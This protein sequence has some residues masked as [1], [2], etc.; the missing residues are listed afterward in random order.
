M[1]LVISNP[2]T[3]ATRTTGIYLWTDTD[4]DAILEAGDVVRLL[5]VVQGVTANQM[6]SGASIELV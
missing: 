6:A 4:G 1:A 5:A 3:Q 2:E